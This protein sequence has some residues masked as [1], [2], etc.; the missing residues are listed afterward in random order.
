MAKRVEFTGP[1]SGLV[2]IL[3]SSTN[4][5]YYPIY[6]TIGF[7]L[8][9]FNPNEYPDNQNGVLQQLLINPNSEAYFSLAAKKILSDDALL[10]YAPVKRGCLFESELYEDFQGHYSY[11]DCL[12]KCKMRNAFQ[13]CGCA[14]VYWSSYYVGSNFPEVRCTL[15]HTKCLNRFQCKR[16]ALP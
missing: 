13:L 15:I 16:N 5:F 9:I 4:D 1:S 7:Q 11:C 12:M 2:F 14:P 6:H 8:Q 10:P 3:N